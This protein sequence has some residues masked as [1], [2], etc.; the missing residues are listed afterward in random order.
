MPTFTCDYFTGHRDNVKH[1]ASKLE[2]VN[3]ILEIGSLEGKASCWMLEN[4]LSPSG[5]MTCIDWFKDS[6]IEDRFR[7]NI[8]EVKLPT[9]TVEILV[10]PSYYALGCL[11]AQKRQYDFI[12][13]D[14]DHSATGVL[15]DA[16]MAFGLLAPGGIILF[17]DYLFDCVPDHHDRPKMSLDA[18][19]NM[20][21][22]EIDF[23]FIN[24]QLALR[25]KIK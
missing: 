16:V 5:T 7:N 21:I 8:K 25:K 19:V 13:V 18:F 17:D 15:T 1:C 23:V 20:F 10:E 14:A 3:F 6:I 9:Q 24:Y 11:I 12:Y 2:N 4:M 22:N